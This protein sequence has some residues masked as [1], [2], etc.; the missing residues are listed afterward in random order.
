MF[1]NSFSEYCAIYE[2]MWK[3]IVDLSRGY[4]SMAHAYCMLDT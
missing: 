2:I 4:D 3:N 1:N